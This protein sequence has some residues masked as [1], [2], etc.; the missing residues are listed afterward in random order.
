ML[1][2]IQNGTNL[3]P[4]LTRPTGFFKSEVVGDEFEKRKLLGRL[5]KKGDQKEEIGNTVI[6]LREEDIIPA[7]RERKIVPPLLLHASEAD[8]RFKKTVWPYLAAGGFDD[9][10]DRILKKCFPSELPHAFRNPHEARLVNPFRDIDVHE[11][12][13]IILSKKL[14]RWEPGSFDALLMFANRFPTFRIPC[15]IVALG[16]EAG[17]I[18]F[19]PCLRITKGGKRYLTTSHLFG[20]FIFPTF[21][22]ITRKK[23]ELLI[24]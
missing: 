18:P 6:K 2:L 4:E 7:V 21:F 13:S 22:L 12:R 5:E 24:V 20:E 9:V 23:K 11:A 14:E 16:S 3:I 19:A 17:V 1:N 10:D 8:I 15:T